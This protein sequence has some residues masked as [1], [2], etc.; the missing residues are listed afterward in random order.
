MDKNTVE[1]AFKAAY[2]MLDAF[3]KEH[4]PHD[5]KHYYEFNAET[6]TLDYHFI[7]EEK[8]E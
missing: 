4:P 6:G 5:D 7:Y 1:D 3:I 2:K 8:D